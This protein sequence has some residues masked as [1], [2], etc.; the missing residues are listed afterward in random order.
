M[1]VLPAAAVRDRG[2]LR[3]RRRSGTWTP[4]P[5]RRTPWAYDRRGGGVPGARAVVVLVAVRDLAPQQRAARAP[6]V[7]A[8]PRRHSAPPR[9]GRA[10]RSATRTSETDTRLAQLDGVEHRD[11]LVV[12]VHRVAPADSP[13]VRALGNQA[14]RTQ[15]RYDARGQI[16]IGGPRPVGPAVM[17][18]GSP[19]PSRTEEPLRDA[20]SHA[21]TLSLGGAKCSVDQRHGELRARAWKSVDGGDHR[22]SQ[23]RWKPGAQGVSLARSRAWKL[24]P[25]QRRIASLRR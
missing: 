7:V 8:L 11:R 5:E 22:R 2:P 23:A 13:V 3:V 18:A 19:A 6:R 24:S 25:R 15:H 12:R 16:P 9:W 1:R 4:P 10:K 14:V 17:A 21:S 20:P